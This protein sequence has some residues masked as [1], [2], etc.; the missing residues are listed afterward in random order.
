MHEIRATWKYRKA[1]SVQLSREVCLVLKVIKESDN[2]RL[3][4]SRKILNTKWREYYM[5]LLK[6]DQLKQIN[7][8]PKSE[9]FNYSDDELNNIM[10][11]D[12]IHYIG[13]QR[14]K[15]KM[16]LP[17]HVQKQREQKRKQKRKQRKK[18]EKELRNKRNEK[19]TIKLSK[20]KIKHFKQEK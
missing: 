3:Q 8:L 20:A 6:I 13:L 7:D 10:D 9:E 17:Y 2:I 12:A 11:N 19:L 16:K 5:K 14:E 15:I 18:Q 4:G 1:T